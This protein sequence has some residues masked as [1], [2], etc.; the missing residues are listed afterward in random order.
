MS[1]DPDDLPW[2][3][4]QDR[5]PRSDSVVIV[6][7][8]VV[9]KRRWLP[10]RLTATGWESTDPNED[11]GDVTHWLL[12]TRPAGTMDHV[13]PMEATSAQPDSGSSP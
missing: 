2:I 12:I 7:H 1:H 11:L 6:S 8:T 13:H 5:L 4:C 10:A 3:A 9:G